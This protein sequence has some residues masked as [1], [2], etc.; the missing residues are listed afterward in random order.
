MKEITN[1][2]SNLYFDDINKE[3][4]YEALSIGKISGHTRAYIKIQDGCNHF[5]SYCSYSIYQRK[6]K[7]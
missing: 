6:S 5:C 4:E 1:T 2:N 3:C 7:K